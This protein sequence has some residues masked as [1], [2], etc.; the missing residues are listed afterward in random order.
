MNGRLKREESEEHGQLY[1]E[2][3]VAS[4]LSS[5][6]K[7]YLPDFVGVCTWYILRR[8]RAGSTWRAYNAWD[9]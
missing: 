3:I 2:R 8:D 5:L 9:A 4:Y 1:G 7:E 6:A